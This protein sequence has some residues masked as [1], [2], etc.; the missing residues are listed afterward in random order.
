MIQFIAVTV[1]VIK[2]DEDET[3]GKRTS[4]LTSIT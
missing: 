2:V 3:E 1:K 4:V